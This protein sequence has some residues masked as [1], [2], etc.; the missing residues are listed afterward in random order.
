MACQA[1]QL[2]ARAEPTRSTKATTLELWLAKPVQ[3]SDNN[4]ACP[5][6]GVQT[7]AT[8]GD[9]QAPHLQGKLLNQEQP[10]AHVTNCCS[11]ATTLQHAGWN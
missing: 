9:Y 10:G 11:A 7:Q 3:H 1:D 2:Q 6:A 4:T 8:Y 5:D